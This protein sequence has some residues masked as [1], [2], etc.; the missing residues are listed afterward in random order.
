MPKMIFIN[1]CPDDQLSGCMILSY[2]AE[3]A[4]RRIQDLIYTNDNLRKERSVLKMV[5]LKTRDVL[6]KFRPQ[7]IGMINQRKLQKLDGVMLT[8]PPSICLSLR[9]H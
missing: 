9:N 8:H 5:K 3:L 7:K 1:Y 6:R 2:K 4:Y